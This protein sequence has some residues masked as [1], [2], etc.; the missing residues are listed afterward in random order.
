MNNEEYQEFIKEYTPKH[1]PLPNNIDLYNVIYNN[2]SVC[3]HIRRGDFLSDEFKND[4]Y[5]CDT[6][7][8]LEGIE[9][10][11]KHV[12]NPIFIFFS[13]DLPWVKENFKLD[14]PVYYEPEN[15]P[16]WETF[17]MM[18]SCKHFII[19]NSTLSWWAQYLSRYSDK[20]VVCPDHW[21]NNK[22]KNEC[23]RLIEPNFHTIQC[24]W[25]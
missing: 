22:T 18:Y 12:D 16:L 17:R 11:K 7:Y 24:K 9:Y 1:A 3:I 6:E 8:Y 10:I 21:Y 14:T 25:H 15:N 13:N 19:S 4:F 20:I 5:V 2:N 23:A